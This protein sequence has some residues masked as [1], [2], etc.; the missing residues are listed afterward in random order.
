MKRVLLVD[1]DVS[2][3]E[4]LT[5]VLEEEGYEVG[6]VREGTLVKQKAKEMKPD[7]IVMDYRMPGED[8]I[9]VTRKLKDDPETRNIPVVM[10][11]ASANLDEKAKQAG[12][13][14]FLPKPFEVQDLLDS[15]SGWV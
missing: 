6:V 14:T 15:L 10:V 1:D 5:W 13:D 9:S 3:V 4:A 2:I 12:V 8:G 11:S 7:V